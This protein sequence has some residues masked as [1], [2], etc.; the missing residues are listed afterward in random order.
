MVGWRTSSVRREKDLIKVVL[1]PKDLIRKLLA[2]LN[3]CH[4]NRFYFML[5]AASASF[6][7]WL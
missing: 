3:K 7:E 6:T 5:Y 2:A 1:L 4:L